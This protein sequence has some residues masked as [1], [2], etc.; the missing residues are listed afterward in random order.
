MDPRLQE[1]INNIK[2]GQVSKQSAIHFCVDVA[3]TTRDKYARQAIYSKELG[4]CCDVIAFATSYV[5][6][7]PELSD[8]AAGPFSLLVRSSRPLLSQVITT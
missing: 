1:H 7:L 8:P 4:K 2:A 3:K 6:G 5:P